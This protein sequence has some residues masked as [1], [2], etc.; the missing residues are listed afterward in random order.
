MTDDGR[1]TLDEL[2]TAVQMT[3]R[4]V[5]AYQTRGLLQPPRRHGRVSV[6][7]TEHVERLRQVRR[8]RQRGASLRLLRTFIAEGRDLDSVWTSPEPAEGDVTAPPPAHPPAG[9]HTSAC[10]ERRRVPLAPLLAAW[11]A[12]AAGA[13]LPTELPAS[14][15]CAVTALADAGVLAPPAAVRLAGALADTAQAVADVAAGAVRA[16]EAERRSVA[17]ARIGEL[18][19]ALVE[20]LVAGTAADARR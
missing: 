20:Q 17:A 11:G 12:D 13:A 6:Y 14:F 18:A 9:G 10:L 2:A 1:M 5:R 4:N 16:V 15:E 19:G 3:A 8:A 7:G